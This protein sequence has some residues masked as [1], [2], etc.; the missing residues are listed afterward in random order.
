MKKILILG[1]LP[2][3]Y[4]GPSIATEIILK[5]SLNKYFHLIHLDT[6]ANDSIR[7]FGQWNFKKIIRN[8]SIYMNM[9]FK[10]ILNLPDLVLIPVSQTTTGFIKDSFFIYIAKLFRRKVLLQLR[11]SDFQNW[12]SNAP[13]IIQRYV[14]KTLTRTEGIIVLGNNLRWL[15]KDYFHENRIY[16]VP[17]GG[18]YTIPRLK[19]DTGK[20]KI[21]QLSN[22]FTGKGI[23]DVLDA[24]MLMN[25]KLKNRFEV[26]LVGMWLEEETKERCIK[27]IKNN[28]LPVTVYPAKDAIKKLDHLGAADIFIFAPRDPEGHPWVI[29]EAM[30]AGLPIISTDRGAIVESVIHG[31]NGFI[32]P[33]KTPE[34][35][36]EK[37]S[38]LITDHSLRK[39]MADESRRLYLENFTEEK[40]VEKMR[41]IFNAVIN[42]A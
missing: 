19:R 36:A 27:Q 23:D 5:S 42:K 9:F 22:L 37:L 38:L 10:I 7:T 28:N 26:E 16:V 32:V 8:I 41:N 30:A 4:M 35:I 24:L 29:V 6:K 21:L 13:S 34:A 12:I 25:K 20:V 33:V 39:K 11:G 14:Y 3:P 15:F 40:M 18:N 2:P 31:V 17:N 1:K